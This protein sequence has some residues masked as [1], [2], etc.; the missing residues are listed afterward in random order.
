LTAGH[1][2]A[3]AYTGTEGVALARRFRPDVVLCDLGLPG[4]TGFEVARVLRQDP[5]TTTVRLI[6]VSG[7]GREEDQRLAREAGFDD[8]LVK[9]VDP[10]ELQRI[11][12]RGQ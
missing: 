2:A 12:A 11:L 1:T 5:A 7:Y 3:V 10:A 6:A 9:P 8:T 4:L